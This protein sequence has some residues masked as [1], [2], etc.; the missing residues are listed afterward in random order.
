MKKHKNTEWISR[1]TFLKAGAATTTLF[2]VGC[3]PTRFSSTEIVLRIGLLTDTH[4]AD[5]PPAGVRYYRESLTKITECI[6]KMNEEKVDFAIHI[7]DFK[8]EDPEPDELKTLQYVT[9]LEK[10]FALFKGPR[11]HVLGNHDIDSISKEQF[12]SKVQNTGIAQ[13]KSFYSFHRRGFHFIVLDATFRQDGIAY[14]KGNFDWKDTF[15]PQEQLHW[16][17]EDLEATQH[18]VLVFV[19]QLLDPEQT[20]EHQIKNAPDVR[21]ILEESGKVL[22]VFQGH[23]HQGGYHLVNGIHYYT[24]QAMVDG[25]GPENNSY[26]ILDVYNNGDMVVNGFRRVEHKALPKVKSQSQT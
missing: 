11:Y 26:A 1:R 18:P 14:D 21:Q 7:G 3:W 5:R 25:S 24:L 2:A 15:I 17:K 16:L 9:D 22:A 20:I 23:Q 4:Y 12:L 6:S 8:D 13:D 10:A 19:H